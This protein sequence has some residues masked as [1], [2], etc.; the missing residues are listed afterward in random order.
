MEKIATETILVVDD[1]RITTE[2]VSKMI[3]RASYLALSDRNGPEALQKLQETLPDLIVLDFMMP[4]MSGL[5]VVQKIKKDPRLSEIPVVMFTAKSGVNEKV[6]CF[7]AGAVGYIEKPV[8]P[9]EF[10]ARIRAVLSRPAP[11]LLPAVKGLPR[12]YTIGIVSVKGGIGA[13]TLT[14][15]LALCLAKKLNTEVA[16]VE[17]RPGEGTWELELGIKTDGLNK[18]LVM[19]LEEIT[20]EAIRNQTVAIDRNVRLLMTNLCLDQGKYMKSA[21]QMRAL[22][23]CLAFVSP[24]TVLD[25]GYS[26]MM[27]TNILKYCD[28]LVLVVESSPATIERAQIIVKSLAEYGFSSAGK[29]LI[30]SVPVNRYQL[31]NS[32][33]ISKIEKALNVPALSPV[34]SDPGLAG[35]SQREKKPFMQ[36]QPNSATCLQFMAIAHDLSSHVK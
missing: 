19:P 36:I 24:V 9:K 11:K 14:L 22:M 6:D 28:E 18:I 8:D 4:D 29:K 17:T 34:P 1:D 32:I 2:I 13:S 26:S 35:R 16:A 27:T 5:E 20:P 21:P 10:L 31:E 25:L 7:Q 15:N 12:G 23:E 30:C 3:E 33:S